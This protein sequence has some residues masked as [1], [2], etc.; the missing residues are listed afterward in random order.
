VLK[1]RPAPGA[2]FWNEG[3]FLRQCRITKERKRKGAYR[4]PLPPELLEA[5]PPELLLEPELMVPTEPLELEEEELLLIIVLP[6][7]LVGA[8][9]VRL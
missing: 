7:L 2:L 5:P 3:V 6:E 8:L 4:P 9:V 1:G